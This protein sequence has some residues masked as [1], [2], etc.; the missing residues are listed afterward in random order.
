MPDRP[1]GQE[2]L[3]EHRPAQIDAAPGGGQRLG[4]ARLWLLWTVANAVGGMLGFGTGGLVTFGVLAALDLLHLDRARS[5]GEV[6]LVLLC[7]C[8]WPPIAGGI[9]AWAQWLVLRWSLGL[10][11]GVGWV[12]MQA[13]LW[14][15]GIALGGLI[16]YLAEF[17]PHGPVATP[18]AFVVAGLVLATPIAL[19]QWSALRAHSSNAWVWLP[20]V[21]VGYAVGFMVG[22][23]A[24][25]ATLQ[26][27][28]VTDG[29]TTLVVAPALAGAAGGCVS[30]LVTGVALVYLV[31][32]AAAPAG[33]H[34]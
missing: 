23:A 14:L 12:R 19:G 8:A 11:E 2:I 26:S 13:V 9:A 24:A 22:T 27:V 30:G 21:P 1:D 32:G 15:V 20:I 28:A 5:A 34:G 4:M 7:A 31:R 33:R 25:G 17:V 18:A 16:I 29:L 6:A 10:G 3:S